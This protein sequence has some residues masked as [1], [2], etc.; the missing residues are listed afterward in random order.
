LWSSACLFKTVLVFA[1][2]LPF[3]FNTY[4]GVRSTDRLLINVVR[5]FGGRKDL[6]LK[7]SFQVRFFT[8]LPAPGLRFGRG[9]VGIIVGEFYAVEGIGKDS[10]FDDTIDCRRCWGIFV[11]MIAA[12]ALTEGRRK[13]ETFH[14]WKRHRRPDEAAC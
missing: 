6:Y 4:A 7:S 1:F 13:L 12:V 5:A 9:L 2:R 8:S 11:L 14:A 3:I 10:R